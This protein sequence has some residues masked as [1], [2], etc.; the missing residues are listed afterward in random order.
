MENSNVVYSV[1]VRGLDTRHY[2]MVFLEK[3]LLL[4]YL[5]EYWERSR[6]RRGLQRRADLLL[7]SMNKRKR[8]EEKDPMDT[9]DILIPY[10]ELRAWRLTAPRTLRRWRRLGGRRLQIVETVNPTLE[11]HVKNGRVVVV[12]FS[13]RVYEL[14]KS[15]A[16]QYLPGKARLGSGR[17]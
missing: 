7:Y 12:E 8:R 17:R 13:P 11:L 10:S 15:L 6:P 5:G 4:R 2:D 3:G 1:R 9:F 16:K 14:V